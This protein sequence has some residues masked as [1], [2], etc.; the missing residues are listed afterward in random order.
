MNKMKLKTTREVQAMPLRELRS[1]EALLKKDLGYLQIELKNIR[2]NRN[3]PN[4]CFSL[5]C[6]VGGLSN[7]LQFVR[8]RIYNI[9]YN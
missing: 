7:H 4:R 9:L 8:S 1:Y 3:Q 5:S 6:K 2:G